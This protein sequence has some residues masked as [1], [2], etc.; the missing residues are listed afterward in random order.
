MDASK[1]VRNELIRLTKEKCDVRDDI[2]QA[3]FDDPKRFPEITETID[4]TMTYIL[5][6]DVMEVE[7]LI[8]NTT[9]RI[10]E[11][12][13]LEF[14]FDL[15]RSVFELLPPDRQQH[16]ES[17]QWDDLDFPGI[18]AKRKE[19]RK[20][21]N[22]SDA[23]SQFNELGRSIPTLQERRVNQGST[24]LTT[25]ADKVEKLR[26]R[27]VRVPGEPFRLLPE[28]VDAFVEMREAAA[29]DGI[30]IRLEDGFRSIATSKKKFAQIGSAQMV[31]KGLSSHNYGAAIDI[32]LSVP[33]AKYLEA[34][35]LM[36]N[37]NKMRNSPIYKWMVLNAHEY[38]WYP[39]NDEPWHW[40]YNPEGFAK[41]LNP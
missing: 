16:W 8:A 1:L 4:R 11:E 40:E 32:K 20:G 14:M 22:E 41:R 33:G 37:V 17:F 10:A 18:N 28:A 30:E 36:N 15:D 26:S 6:A 39:W 29:L 5:E 27:L 38:G 12:I 35:T 19:T 25:K 23:T 13:E 21:P 9:D 3:T 2:V 24:A 34:T 7:T 31:A